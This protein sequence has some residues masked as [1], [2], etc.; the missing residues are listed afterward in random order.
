MADDVKKGSD[1]K[2]YEMQWDCKFCGTT[3]LLGKTHRFC[4]NCGGQQDPSWRYFPSDAEKV[5]VQDHVYVGVDKVC[6]ACQSVSGGAAEF[7]GNCGSPLDKAAAAQ[8]LGQ[9]KTGEGQEFSTESLKERQQ[10]AQRPQ[11]VAVEK[12]K[13]GGSK[14]WIIL[15][16]IAVV[17]IGGILFTV[18]STKT[19]SVY[20]SG[21]R[22]EREIRVE[23]LQA[24]S[25]KSDC[26]SEP[27]GAY[28]IDRRREQVDTRSIPDGETCQRKQVDQGDGTFRE[29][30]ECTTK[31]REEPVY[32]DVCYYMVNTWNY[33]RSLTSD[34]DKSLAVTWPQVS[35]N[36]GSCLGCEREGGRDET[37]YV[38][39]QGDGGKTFECPVPADEWNQTKI[40]QA[41][42]IEIGTVLKDARCDTLKPAA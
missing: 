35:L 13:S 25:G 6:P 42:S 34:G 41:F 11:A 36:T 1:G 22:W 38:V 40:E 23:S 37:Y 27:M 5:A 19:S 21:F 9:R 26:G 31:Y 33:S 4:P 14:L 3:K 39:F 10:A 24:V 2:V 28:S 32:G 18:F 17:V 15:G 12:P 20:V 8:T 7:C 29:E 16:V 30:Q